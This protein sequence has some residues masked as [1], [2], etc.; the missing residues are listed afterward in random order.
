M[1]FN[2]GD[3][4]Q[5]TETAPWPQR[6]GCRGTVVAP[7]SDGT[8]PQPARGESLVKL[9]EDPIGPLHRPWSAVFGNDSLR[10]VSDRSVPAVS[11]GFDHS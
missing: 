11:E 10:L 6:V 3:R 8:Y 2:V 5:V 7:M 1:V 9:D 4:I